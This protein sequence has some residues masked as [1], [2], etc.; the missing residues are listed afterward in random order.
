MHPKK[1]VD[2]LAQ[3]CT[4]SGVVFARGSKVTRVLIDTTGQTTGVELESGGVIKADK[5]VIALGYVQS[6][7][8]SYF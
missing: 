8:D 2:K 1:F 6:K 4:E 5:V 3:L 7:H